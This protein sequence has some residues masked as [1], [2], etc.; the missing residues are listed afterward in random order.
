MTKNDVQG[1]R[2]IA[3]EFFYY[4]M[5]KVLEDLERKLGLKEKDQEPI[6]I[7]LQIED[8]GKP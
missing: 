6:S 2:L 7:C 1:K 4:E 8:E 5:K 3:L